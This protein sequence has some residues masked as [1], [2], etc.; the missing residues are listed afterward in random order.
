[1][2][3]VSFDTHLQMCHNSSLVFCPILWAVFVSTTPKFCT[4]YDT[5]LPPKLTI[6]YNTI[7]YN[8]WD[9]NNIW[10]IC[11]APIMCLFGLMNWCRVLLECPKVVFVVFLCPENYDRFKNVL[12]VLWLIDFTAYFTKMMG[13]LPF[14]LIPPQAITDLGFCQCSTMIEN[15]RGSVDNILSFC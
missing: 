15:P 5:P 11:F 6:Y 7:Y 13:V 9:C 8:P 10:K 14:A 12:L 2:I 1:M 3:A 4:A